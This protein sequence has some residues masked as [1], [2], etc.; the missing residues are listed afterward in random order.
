MRTKQSSSRLYYKG[1]NI[2]KDL[3]TVDLKDT[4]LEDIQHPY[5]PTDEIVEKNM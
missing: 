3:I 4:R 5:Q 2:R 1:D